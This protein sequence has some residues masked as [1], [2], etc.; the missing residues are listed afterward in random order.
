MDVSRTFLVVFF[1]SN[2]QTFYLEESR[3]DT[4]GY[5]RLERTDGSYLFMYT[6]GVRHELN[7]MSDVKYK[8]FS[9]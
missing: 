6:Q 3:K 7:L 4:G 5:D 8:S 2:C 1:S 9:S